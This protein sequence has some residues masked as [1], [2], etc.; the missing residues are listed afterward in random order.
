MDDSYQ[1]NVVRSKLTRNI[2]ATLD[3]VH[4]EL[5]GALRDFIPATDQGMFHIRLK[6][7]PIIHVQPRVG[8]SIFLTNDATYRLSDIESGGCGCTSMCVIVRPLVGLATL[9]NA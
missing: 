4:D 6:S 1:R 9:V 3:P 2:A 5:V 7:V 8:Q